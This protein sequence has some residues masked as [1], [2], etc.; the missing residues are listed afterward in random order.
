MKSVFAFNA[1]TEKQLG[2]YSGHDSVVTAMT[3]DDWTLYTGSADLTVRSYNIKSGLPKVVLKGHKGRII[4]IQ[5]L[6]KQRLLTASWDNTCIL[7]DLKTASEIPQGMDTRK[8]IIRQYT[9]HTNTISV[10]K[11]LSDTEFLTASSD[12]SIRRWNVNSPDAVT[13]YTSSAKKKYPFLC[14]EV[15]DKYIFAG[16][17]D[18]NVYMF[19]LATGDFITKWREGGDTQAI[20]VSESDHRV[21]VSGNYNYIAEYDFEAIA[22]NPSAKK[23]AVTDYRRSQDQDADDGHDL[24]RRI[25]AI[26]WSDESKKEF[27]SG[28]EDATCRRWNRKTGKSVQVYKG[29]NLFNIVVVVA[30]ANSVFASAPGDKT[31]VRGWMK[32]SGEVRA[33]IH[34]QPN[35]NIYSMIYHPDTNQFHTTAGYNVEAR[36]PNTG[37]VRPRDE[38]LSGHTGQVNNIIMDPETRLVYTA[39]RDRSVKVWDMVTRKCEGT[40]ATNASW[41]GRHKGPVLSLAV[42]SS[43]IDGAGTQHA[44]EKVGGNSA[45]TPVLPRSDRSGAGGATAAILNASLPTAPRDSATPVSNGPHPSPT[46]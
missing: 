15:S 23:A 13:T 44:R 24:A 12:G 7:W 34:S 25:P 39:S 2:V 22:A 5:V 18:F 17:Q 10:L 38:R 42:G 3:V 28:S 11:M 32:D 46:T 29:P 16:G 19:D 1:R 30:T 9:G 8:A 20:L 31:A 27:I 26:V 45:P 33:R 37:A 6:P 35:P 41:M 14:M 40:F 21:L 4:G 43:F 36:D